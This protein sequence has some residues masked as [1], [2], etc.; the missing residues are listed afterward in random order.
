MKTQHDKIIE[1]MLSFPKIEWWKP[2]DFMQDDKWFVGYEASARLSELAKMYPE[3]IES[4]QDGKYKARR[5]K[6]EN[7][8]EW[9]YIVDPRLMPATPEQMRLV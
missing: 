4:K 8:Q 9:Q 1:K 5:L 7:S 3:M 2:Q 6:L